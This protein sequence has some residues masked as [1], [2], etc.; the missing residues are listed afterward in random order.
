MQSISRLLGT[1]S[2]ELRH[3]EAKAKGYTL[4]GGF[5]SPFDVRYV[6]M[7][8]G[9]V[10]QYIYPLFQSCVITI[11]SKS[12]NPVIIILCAMSQEISSIRIFKD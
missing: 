9:D 1:I 6:A 10:S 11:K 5:V 8:I 7:V 12:I 3:S 2:T 4:R